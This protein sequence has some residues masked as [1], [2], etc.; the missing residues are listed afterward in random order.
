ML[1]GNGTNDAD[2][3]LVEIVGNQVRV[4]S[5]A[6]IDFETNP[7]LN[8]NIQVT[9][10]GGLTYTKAVAVNVL[11]VIEGPT[12]NIQ[13]VLDGSDAGE[14]G[15]GTGTYGLYQISGI[16]GRSGAVLAVSDAD[17]EEDASF[18]DADIEL[19]PLALTASNGK[20]LPRT[21]TPLAIRQDGINLELL[22]KP[23]LTANTYQTQDFSIRTGK[24]IGAPTLV[25]TSLVSFEV[26]YNQDLNQ[27]T[28]IGPAITIDS[29]IDSA[30]SGAGNDGLGSYGLYKVSGINGTSASQ[31]VI[32]DADLDEKITI[33]QAQLSL[34]LPLL[35][36]K[37]QP[38]P[39]AWTPL[40]LRSDGSNIEL[41]YKSSASAPS[42]Q[43][44]DFSLTTGEAV[45]SATAVTNNL[46]SFEVAYDQDLNNDG[47]IGSAV[48]IDSAIDASD[49][50]DTNEGLGTYGL[51]RISGING[52]TQSNLAISVAD[53]Q[54]GDT[55][56]QGELTTLMPLLLSNG[57]ALPTTWSPLAIRRNGSNIELL[58]QPSASATT[59]QTQDFSLTTGR[60]VG[61]ATAATS[62][63][64][65]FEVSYD[66]DLNNDGVIGPAITIDAV[67]DSA[68]LGE[69]NDGTGTY[70]LYRISGVNGSTRSDLAISDADLEEET[71]FPQSELTTLIPLLLSNGKA[72]P[73]TWSP[74][75]IRRDGSNIELL[76]KPSTS[77]TT[78]Q[79]LDFS[80][81]TGRA[82][83]SA[84]AA[85]SNLLSF[86][87]SY[88][89]DLTGDGVIGIKTN[90]IGA[91]NP[92][93]GS[94]AK[95]TLTAT[96][97][98]IAYGGGGDDQLNISSNFDEFDPIIMI[99][100]VGNDTYNIRT[101]ALAVI[102]DLGGS[103]DTRDTLTGL[104]G[105]RQDWS[106]DKVE[107]YDYLLSHATNGTRVLIVDPLGR[108]SAGNRLET[109]KFANSPAALFSTL[110]QGKTSILSGTEY[111][112]AELTQTTGLD[113]S[114]A[115][116][117]DQESG[118][119][120]LKSDLLFNN[121]LIA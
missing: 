14:D 33:S 27:D 117:I 74:L 120:A 19:K 111:T 47:I 52:S 81:T 64:L 70:G 21:W 63:L 95:D 58:Y 22:Y 90:E 3:A 112:Y 11:D 24:A 23:I 46:L 99:G 9:D 10:N 82:V 72:L 79:T 43:T 98:D 4:K 101:G 29:V 20:A 25:S 107:S 41:L 109:V 12:Y 51:Y 35:T 118:P 73:A 31:I 108:E 67:I 53:L 83:G 5:G 78:Y 60:A 6:S 103:R 75:A 69:G 34:L 49:L 87:V 50:G 89:Q 7:Q 1:S 57:S 32:A 39:S 59:Y 17:L 121:S 91:T 114:Y 86:E 71:T 80:L 16:T 92:I 56:S 119:L 8:L 66:Q 104:A 76:Y 42:Y 65:S 15:D 62:N 26:A 37:G 84:T 13:T 85:T 30:D 2:N 102:Y 45:G 48:K 40:A 44:Q 94:S 28:F 55:F 116:G 61:A 105:T 36:S 38:L 18:T 115:L 54:E 97:L 93:L 77:A 113:I 110:T 68:D 88:D 106:M 100:G 96:S